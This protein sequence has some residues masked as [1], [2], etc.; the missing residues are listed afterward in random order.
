MVR[1]CL[2]AL[3]QR[4]IHVYENIEFAD[5]D[6]WEASTMDELLSAW[7][8]L[9]ALLTS[10]IAPEVRVCYRI[11]VTCGLERGGTLTLEFSMSLKRQWTTEIA[12]ALG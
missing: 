8:A 11:A 9:Q 7:R 3:A 2:L 10:T 1:R 4:C 5:L 12:C 6:L